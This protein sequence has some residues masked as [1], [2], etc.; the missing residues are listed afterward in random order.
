MIQGCEPRILT[1]PIWAKQDSSAATARPG[2]GHPQRGTR[3]PKPDRKWCRFED[4]KSGHPAP[5]QAGLEAQS[6]SNLR[7]CF[8]DLYCCPGMGSCHCNAR[9]PS[10]EQQGTVL[11][12]QSW[13]V[14]ELSTTQRR[15]RINQPLARAAHVC[16]PCG[17]LPSTAGYRSWP[18]TRPPLSPARPCTIPTYTCAF[19]ASTTV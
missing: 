11:A 19:P 18:S 16:W 9:G 2:T 7:R 10:P 4:P 3:P 6:Y 1:A 14:L 15:L 5:H 8:S 13:H 17:L 12:V